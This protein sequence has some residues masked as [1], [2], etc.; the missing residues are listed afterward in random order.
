LE[1]RSPA[2]RDGESL[3]KRKTEGEK[4]EGERRWAMREGEDERGRRGQR[5]DKVKISTL[6]GYLSATARVH[7]HWEQTP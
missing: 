3:E 7:S 5:R 6:N 4:E 2:L 1:A